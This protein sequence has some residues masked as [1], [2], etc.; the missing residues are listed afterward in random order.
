MAADLAR[1]YRSLDELAR[2]TDGELQQVEGVGPNIAAAVVDWFA[3]PA[4]RAVLK[5]LE[6][7]G[8]WPVTEQKVRAGPS[9]KGML[10]GLTFVVT[11]TLPTYSRDDIKDLIQKNG[12]KVTDS[13]SKKTSYLVVGEAAGSK[14]DKARELGVPALD[15]AAFLKLLGR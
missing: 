5:K 7:V 9:G 3:R 4:N 1:V 10:D 6:E 14:L 15:E 11:G 13:V 8:V 2:A 12:G